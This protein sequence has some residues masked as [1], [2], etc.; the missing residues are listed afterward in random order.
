M[1]LVRKRLPTAFVYLYT[2]CLFLVVLLLLLLS[3]K[4]LSAEFAAVSELSDE[5]F[6]GPHVTIYPQN[7]GYRI[8]SAASLHPCIEWIFHWVCFPAEDASAL[9]RPSTGYSWAM[10]LTPVRW[11]TSPRNFQQFIFPL[12][13]KGMTAISYVKKIFRIFPYHGHSN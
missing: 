9:A 7:G 2:Q 3:V 10:Y 4:L 11:G 5:K 6:N 12:H 13:F 1:F 8:D